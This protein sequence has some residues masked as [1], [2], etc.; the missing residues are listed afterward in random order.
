MWGQPH[1]PPKEHAPLES[2]NG[3][4][5][6]VPGFG[7]GNTN[8]RTGVTAAADYFRRRRLE[9]GSARGGQA[10]LDRGAGRLAETGCGIRTPRTPEASAVGAPTASKRAAPGIMPRQ[11]A[12]RN[13]PRSLDPALLPS[14]IPRHFEHEKGRLGVKS[15][16]PGKVKKVPEVGLEPTR[17]CGHQILS[18]ARLPFRHSGI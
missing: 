9:A 6:R 1:A 3:S 16:R 13:C 5:I 8:R 17:P 11:C 7:A 14:R 12:D 15:K 10:V 2:H 18:L 4:T